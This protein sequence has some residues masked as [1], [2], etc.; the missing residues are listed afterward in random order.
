MGR[1]SRRCS[2]PRQRHRAGILRF[3]FD[4]GEESLEEVDWETFFQT[5]EDK[6]LALLAQDEIDGGKSRF[7]KFVER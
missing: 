5:F 7:F 3:D 4:G 2:R 6:K 1:G